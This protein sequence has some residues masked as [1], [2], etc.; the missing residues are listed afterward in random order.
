MN[1]I[2]VVQDWEYFRTPTSTI[3]LTCWVL[4]KHHF[5]R[6]LASHFNETVNALTANRGALAG[7]PIIYDSGSSSFI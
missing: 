1:W 3:F 6:Q 4:H 2:F 7:I 5:T